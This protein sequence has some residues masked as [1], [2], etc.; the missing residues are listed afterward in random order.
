MKIVWSK[1]ANKQFSKI[2][3]R[4]KNRIKSRLEKMNDKASPISD[5]KKL[6]FP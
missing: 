4:Y 3:N 1:T 6:S 2:D 5:I